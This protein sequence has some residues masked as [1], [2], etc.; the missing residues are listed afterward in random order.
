MEAAAKMAKLEYLLM[1]DV[2]DKLQQPSK[3]VGLDNSTVLKP[4]G[5]PF[6]KRPKKLPMVKLRSDIRLPVQ[7]ADSLQKTADDLGYPVM[8]LIRKIVSRYFG[9]ETE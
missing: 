1:K 4:V 5:D 7:V 3:I 9:V 6:T 2:E 8:T